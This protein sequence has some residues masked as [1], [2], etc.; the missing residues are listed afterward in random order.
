VRLPRTKA[1]QDVVFSAY[2]FN[3][4]RVKR[5]TMRSTFKAPALASSLASASVQAEGFKP[6]P[7]GGRGL[8][9]LSFD[10]GMRILAA[11]QSDEFALEDQRLR[12][13]LLTFSLINDGLE[14]F[15]ADFEPKDSKVWLDEWLRYGVKRVPA[16][17]DEVKSGTVK[18]A[19]RGGERGAVRVD[20]PAQGAAAKGAKPAQQ[21][22]LFDFAKNRRPVVLGER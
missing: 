15:N 14:A 19:N 16:L 3:D 13:G 11:S 17:A 5:E 7:M 22:A 1:G 18:V 9:Q 2:A 21:P 12:Y 6:G 20:V 8:G 10:K 4:D